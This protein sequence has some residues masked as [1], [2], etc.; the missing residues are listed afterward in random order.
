MLDVFLGVLTFTGII[1]VPQSDEKGLHW[2]RIVWWHLQQYQKGGVQKVFLITN[3]CLMRFRQASLKC[4][5]LCRI[6]LYLVRS[7][8]WSHQD[9]CVSYPA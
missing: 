9:I 5:Q 4:I 7:S 2:F 1:V 8:Q 3:S 6:L